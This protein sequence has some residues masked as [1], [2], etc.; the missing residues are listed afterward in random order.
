MVVI[1]SCDSVHDLTGNDCV[2]GNEDSHLSTADF[3]T[4]RLRQDIDELDVPY[5]LV[6]LYRSK[7]RCT[8]S[9]CLIRVDFVVEF[10]AEEFSKLLLDL[11]HSR[12]TSYKYDFSI[13]FE[14]CWNEFCL[15][16]DLEDDLNA[17]LK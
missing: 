13:S 8:D 10:L 7:S 1:Q 4:D 6:S 12:G 17:S 5:E 9:Y 3:N 2:L 15:I 14:V 11:N 16:D